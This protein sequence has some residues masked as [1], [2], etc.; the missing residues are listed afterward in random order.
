MHSVCNVEVGH[1][2]ECV[3]GVGGSIFLDARLRPGVE[4]CGRRVILLVAVPRF[5]IS[6]P[7][8]TTDDTTYQQQE[9]AI[10]DY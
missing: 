8:L 10:N 4:E 7:K 6:I 2:A 1:V 3:L 9:V 5:R